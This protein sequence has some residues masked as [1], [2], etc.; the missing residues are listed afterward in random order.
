VEYRDFKKRVAQVQDMYDRLLTLKLN[1]VDEVFRIRE[2]YVHQK[3]SSKIFEEAIDENTSN[4]AENIPEVIYDDP[5]SVPSLDNEDSLY[6]C[7]QNISQTNSIESTNNLNDDERPTKKRLKTKIL[8]QHSRNE[9]NNQKEKKKFSCGECQKTFSSKTYMKF[10]QVQ[11]HGRTFPNFKTYACKECPRIFHQSYQ[12]R[13]HMNTHL[14]EAEKHLVQCK[15]CDNRFVSS[16]LSTH[17]K[18]VHLNKRPF[19]CEI[20]GFKVKTVHALNDHKFTRTDYTPYECEICKKSFK[21]KCLLK[22]CF[23]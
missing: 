9:N 18:R 5:L 1:I 3:E 4:K 10:H 22:V 11:E 17:I 12:L 7:K 16:N 13:N 23:T 21:D 19:V 15:Y 2:Y 6:E 20:C 8:F 14:P